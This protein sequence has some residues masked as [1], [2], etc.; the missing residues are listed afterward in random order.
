[1]MMMNS[2][3]ACDLVSSWRDYLS[4][5]DVSEDFVGTMSFREAALK[6]RGGYNWSSSVSATFPAAGTEEAGGQIQ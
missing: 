6:Q 4:E 2:L 3:L 5:L 1:M